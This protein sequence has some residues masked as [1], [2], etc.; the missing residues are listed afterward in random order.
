MSQEYQ[1]KATP[2]PDSEGSG[3]ERSK[4]P[5]QGRGA[6]ASPAELTLALNT[7]RQQNA[8]LQK[9]LAAAKSESGSDLKKLT[10]L[11]ASALTPKQPVMAETDNINRSSD[12]KNSKTVVDG[13]SL[14]EAQQALQNYRNERKKP[15]S[16]SKA[17]RNFVGDALSITV[18]G[19]R[20]SIPADGQTY[21]INETHWE[22]AKERLAKLDRLTADTEPQII[23]VG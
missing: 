6:T 12:F 4:A 15:I 11:L 10:E 19:V 21:M 23:E 20:V 9:E 7:L 2:V 17:M 3:V 13:R 22:H 5:A 1:N 8:E 18:N 16:I 14:M